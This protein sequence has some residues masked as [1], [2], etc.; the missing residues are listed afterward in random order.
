M[1]LPG[2]FRARPLAHR[3]LHG[4]GRAENSM[5]AFLAAGEA[6]YGIELDVQPSADGAAMVFH[7]TTLGRMT[8]REG[9]IDALTADELARCALRGGGVIDTLAHVL[10]RVGQTP[11]LVEIKDQAR[12]PLGPVDGRLEK[13]VAAALAAHRGPAAVMSFNPASMRLMREFAP[14][15]PR[16]L[17]T[18]AFESDAWG[19]APEHAARLAAIEDYTQVGAGFVSHDAADPDRPALG[20]VRASGGAVLCWTIKSRAQE[21]AARRWADNITFE[22]YRPATDPATA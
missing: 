12:D 10:A 20:A 22:R 13:A 15:V 18:C 5:A 8:G 4:E 11:V 2:V 1:T 16:G 9:R 19:I 3:G 21:I 14:H 7:D 17:T 6:G